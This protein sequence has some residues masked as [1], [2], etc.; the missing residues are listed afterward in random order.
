[1]GS[2]ERNTGMKRIIRCRWCEY[3]VQVWWKTKDGW[4]KSGWTTLQRHA[5][6]WHSE[7][8]EKIKSWA[9]EKKYE[10]PRWYSK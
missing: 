3:S 1:M 8:L 6:R 4:P 10:G 5:D 2:K 9:K 7:E